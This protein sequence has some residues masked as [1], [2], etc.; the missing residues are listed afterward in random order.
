MSKA[1][2]THSYR[3]NAAVSVAAIVMLI[4]GLLVIL[5]TGRWAP[6]LLVLLVIPLLAAVWGWRAGT[7]VDSEA[8]TVRAAF[9]DRRVAW[10]EI[11][12]FVTDRKGRVAA[13]LTSGGHLRLTAVRPENLPDIV[14]ASG[15]PLTGPS[16]PSAE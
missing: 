3:H 1:S 5:S 13:E 2:P 16:S 4:I 8:I 15:A 6:Y 10:S 14:A 9:G 12:G 11:A 7:D